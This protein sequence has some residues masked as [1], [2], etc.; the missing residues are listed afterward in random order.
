MNHFASLLW[1]FGFLSG[2]TA[3]AVAQRLGSNDTEGISES[4]NAKCKKRDL[5]NDGTSML[6]L[7][8]GLLWLSLGK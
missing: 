3:P 8:Q 1:G 4:E 7:M 5:S 2:V 6:Y